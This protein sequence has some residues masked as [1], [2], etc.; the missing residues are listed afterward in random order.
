MYYEPRPAVVVEIA[1]G[2]RGEGAVRSPRPV[3]SS[4][5]IVA[6][7]AEPISNFPRPSVHNFTSS[8][9][10]TTISDRLPCRARVYDAVRQAL[11]TTDLLIQTGG[12]SAIVLN[13]GV[14]NAEIISRIEL[15]TWHRYRVASE[16]T[17]SS[18]LLLSRYP[19]AKS[20]SELQVRLLSM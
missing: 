17:Q 19:C 18:M 7:C 13:L 20:S 5:T 14:V 10:P 11:P 16:Q 1:D 2:F 6:R 12:F 15:S 4:E 8:L 3:L 9:R